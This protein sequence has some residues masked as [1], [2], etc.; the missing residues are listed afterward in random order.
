MKLTRFGK[1]AP[2]GNFR[3]DADI[4]GNLASRERELHRWQPDEK[5]AELSLEETNQTSGQSWDQFEANE[6]LFGVKSDFNPDIYTTKVDRSHPLYQQRDAIAQKIAR[7]IESQ[8]V[9]PNMNPHLAEERGLS[10]GDDSGKDEEDRYGAVQRTPAQA[11]LPQIQ[12]PNNRYTPPALRA[13]TAL[14][15]VPGAPHDP[16]IISSQLLRPETLQQKQQQHQQ[17]PQAP[18]PPPP[19]I[20]LNQQPPNKGSEDISAKPKEKTLLPETI[21]PKRG[22]PVPSSVD[23]SVHSSD[24]PLPQE[25]TENFKR[26]VNSEKERYKKKKADLVQRDRASKLEELK[27]FSQNFVLKTEVP[28]DLVPILAKDKSKQ[29]EIVEKAKQNVAK[30]TSTP[31]TATVQ[32]SQTTRVPPPNSFAAKNP[33]EFQLTRQQLLQGFPPTQSRLPRGQQIQQPPL[34]TRLHQIAVD[35]RAGHQVSVRSPVPIPEHPHSVPTGPAAGNIPTA[36]KSTS[37]SSAAHLRNLSAKAPEFKPNPN[38]ISFTPTLGGPSTTATPSPTTSAHAHSSRAASP[39]AFFGNKKV[40]TSQEKPLIADRFNPF[41]RMKLATPATPAPKGV[42]GREI[43]GN[44]NDYIE[45]AFVTLPTWPTTEQ[46]RDKKWEQMFAKPEFSMASS[47]HSSQPPHA[48]P[49]PHHQQIPSH[50]PHIN[51]PPHIAHQPH[52]HMPQHMGIPPPHYEPEQHL[53]QIPPSVMPSPSFHNATVA[54]YQQS[55]VAHH[56]QIGPMYPSHQQAQY[57]IP[58]GPSGPAYGYYGSFRGATGAGPMMVQGPQPIP[59][60]AGQFIHHPPMYS[61]QQPHAYLQGAP[62][63][64][65]SGSQGHPSPGR[66]APMMM[67]QGSQQGT[68]AGPQMM[69]YTLQPGQTAP[70]YAGQGQQQSELLLHGQSWLPPRPQSTVSLPPVPSTPAAKFAFSRA[71]SPVAPSPRMRNLHLSPQPA[72]ATPLLASPLATYTTPSAGGSGLSSYAL[73]RSQTGNAPMG[74]GGG[75]GRRQDNGSG[76]SGVYMAS[77]MMM[78][79]SLVYNAYSN[80]GSVGM[81]RGQP[82]PHHQGG[83]PPGPFYH[84]PHFP[85]GGRGN[86]FGHLQQHQGGQHAPPPPPPQSQSQQAPPEDED[87]K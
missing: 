74:A 30:T 24:A 41:K 38:A 52:P 55:P 3:T 47:I 4:A 26:F 84:G 67:H 62:P 61:P 42:P 23:P 80:D 7:E 69:Q 59:Y 5:T 27:K 77:V 87:T 6:R 86:N 20:T 14:P 72:S 1:G 50:I 68:P 2:A 25:V 66:A 46:N 81:I 34:S 16:A 45:P 18:R 36:P 22:H 17:P 85:P 53:R 15:T 21:V 71:A 10:W 8:G 60:P 78:P 32:P 43:R 37:P 39:S 54:P 44:S 12:Q 75:R 19:Q 9:G 33:E 40:K 58:S 63:P 83:P 13:P 31:P 70:I 56:S 48:M 82:H 51:P 76:S 57:A 65:P 11:I 28:Q 64:P 79:S 49:Q 29:A 73:Q 35:R